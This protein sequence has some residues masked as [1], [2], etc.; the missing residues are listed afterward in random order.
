LPPFPLPPP[1]LVPPPLETN[2]AAV[3]GSDPEVE[4]T[5]PSEDALS[6]FF[7]LREG[8]PERVAADDDDVF[9]G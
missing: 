8:R 7:E 4:T 1:P 3:V 6:E 9:A 2:N 5:P